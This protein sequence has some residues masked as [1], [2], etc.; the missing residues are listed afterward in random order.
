MLILMK[1]NENNDKNTNFENK[2]KEIYNFFIK[3]VE[4]EE[5]S[6]GCE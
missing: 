6:L 2:N 5:N 4:N 3:I 1:L